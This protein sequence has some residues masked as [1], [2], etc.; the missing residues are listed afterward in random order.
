MKKWLALIG[1]SALLVGCGHSTYIKVERASNEDEVIMKN[2]IPDRLM[3][4]DGGKTKL[5]QYH[6]SSSLWDAWNGRYY[7]D[8]CDFF[9]EV[10]TTTKKVVSIN[11][12]GDA[13]DTD[14]NVKHGQNEDGTYY[15][16]KHQQ[17]KKIQ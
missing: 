16:E 9:Y 1:C 5:M 3:E 4:K 10:D 7:S 2:G 6:K 17:F 11:A 15:I 13:C 8:F 12:K 14:E